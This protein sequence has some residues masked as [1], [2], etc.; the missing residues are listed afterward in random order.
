MKT[1]SYW[2]KD[3]GQRDWRILRRGLLGGVPSLRLWIGFPCSALRQLGSSRIPSL[4]W[5]R[6]REVWGEDVR[7]IG[8]VSA[9]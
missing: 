2:R 7:W 6:V 8:K 1:K 9:W 3:E 5:V 4:V